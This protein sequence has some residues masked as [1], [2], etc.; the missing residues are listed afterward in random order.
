MQ[1]AGRGLGWLITELILVNPLA[2]VAAASF[3]GAKQKHTLVWIRKA[4]HV[5]NLAL[6]KQVDGRVSDAQELANRC[7]SPTGS[8]TQSKMRASRGQCDTDLI[9]S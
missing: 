7:Q 6:T 8:P 5:T 9:C 2:P 3:S 4:S 1:Q